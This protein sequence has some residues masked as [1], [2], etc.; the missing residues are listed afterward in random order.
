MEHIDC[1]LVGKT[2]QTI[3]HHGLEIQ[4]AADIVPM[5]RVSHINP[6]DKRKFAHDPM[7]DVMFEEPIDPPEQMEGDGKRNKKGKHRHS[8]G[9]EGNEKQGTICRCFFISFI[10]TPEVQYVIS[11]L[12]LSIAG[13]FAAPLC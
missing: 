3:M 2:P 13:H 9:G 7:P 5:I 11:V 1:V 10:I 6:Y 4:F 8:K 12:L